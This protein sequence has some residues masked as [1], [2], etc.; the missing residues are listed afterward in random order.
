MI[1]SS[2]SSKVLYHGSKI[3]GLKTIEPNKST[4]GNSWVYATKDPVIASLFISECDDFNTAICGNGSGFYPFFVVERHK[5][6]LSK[7]FNGVSGSIYTIDAK[8]FK[9]N[10]TGWSAELVSTESASVVSETKITDLLEYITDAE[11]K[12][13]IKIYYYPDRPKYIPQDDSDI[14][15][16]AVEWSKKK[17][18]VKKRFLE[19][20][21]NLKDQFEKLEAGMS[22]KITKESRNSKCIIS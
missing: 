22:S 12:G 18:H 7:Y 2:S 13:K 5:D 21:P 3:S 9:A 15:A 17:E 11:K 10:L 14:V 8:N 19:I 20:H 4:H 1:L 6:V 16:K